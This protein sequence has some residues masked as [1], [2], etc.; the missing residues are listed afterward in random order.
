MD[1]ER[2]IQGYKS[3]QSSLRSSTSR[4]VAIYGGLVAFKLSTLEL[5]VNMDCYGCEKRVR[6]AL[7][8]LDGVDSIEIDMDQQ[9][10]TVTGWAEQEDVLKIVRKTGRNAELWPFPYSL[11]YFG[12]TEEY[13]NL[14]P[15]HSD[16]TT[17]FQ[18]EQP[19]TSFRHHVHGYNGQEHYTH[20]ELPNST[21]HG[22]QTPF[23]AF[24][25]ENVNA[26]LIM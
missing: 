7:E 9:K 14:Y 11:E 15:Y 17:Y 16:P 5:I 1:L 3:I 24:S 2:A 4:N 22:S 26:C 21:V 19:D 18:A 10:V 6:R 23:V 20:Q 12:F 13:A 25:D 8:N